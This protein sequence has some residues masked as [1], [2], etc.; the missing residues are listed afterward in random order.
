MCV[1]RHPG[2]S[3]GPLGPVCWSPPLWA[4]WSAPGRQ[5]RPLL[6]PPPACKQDQGAQEESPAEMPLSGKGIWHA[7]EEQ[8]MNAEAATRSRSRH[9]HRR[10]AGTEQQVAQRTYAKCSTCTTAPAHNPL[11][12]PNSLAPSPP[13]SNTSACNPSFS[14]RIPPAAA[15]PNC[16]HMPPPYTP[17]TPSNT[18][19]PPSPSSLDAARCRDV[20]VLD[21]DHVIQPHAVVGPTPQCHAPL[22]Q[23]AQPGGGLARL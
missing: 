1:T 12:P 17:P 4:C 16:Y 13:P 9:R 22:V 19:V 2:D 11:Q 23:Q 15:T 5:S 6:L 8:S 14:P 18:S 21:H 20:V 7:Q 10:A 3:P